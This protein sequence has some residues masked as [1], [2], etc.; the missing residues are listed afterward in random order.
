[1][2]PARDK[3]ADIIDSHKLTA[4]WD[5]AIYGAADDILA[6]LPDMIAPLVWDHDLGQFD[7]RLYSVIGFRS[8]FYV[9]YNGSCIRLELLNLEE[10]KSEANAHHRA[11]I[12]AAFQ[13][14]T[15]TP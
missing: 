12:M 3:I 14:P 1:M 4:F 6:A 7:N 15:I 2:T 9:E 8:G 10:A 11:T 5:D 13:T